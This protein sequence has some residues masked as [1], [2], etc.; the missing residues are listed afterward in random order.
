[1]NA[2]KSIFKQPVYEISEVRELI[3]SVPET[4]KQAREQAL[5][6]YVQ[7]KKHQENL[8][9][10]TCFMLLAIIAMLIFFITS[11]DRLFNAAQQSYLTPEMINYLAT[12]IPNN[13][14]HHASSVPTS[15]H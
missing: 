3:N 2:F 6:R 10:A 5:S 12:P 14:Y 15:P 8:L 9:M 11:T 1:M 13:R 7:Q 4:P